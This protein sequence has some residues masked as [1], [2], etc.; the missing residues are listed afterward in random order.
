M[1]QKLAPPKKNSR[2]M[3]PVSPTFCISAY[4]V[5]FTQQFLYVCCSFHS[6]L[7]LYFHLDA[8]NAIFTRPHSQLSVKGN[9]SL[10]LWIGIRR[11]QALSYVSYIPH[12]P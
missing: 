12:E 7:S 6:V 2:D 4:A 11:D 3:S 10:K 1:A 5:L 8:L 9:T